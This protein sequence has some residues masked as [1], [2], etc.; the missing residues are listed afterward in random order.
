MSHE[1]VEL[2]RRGD[3]PEQP[4]AREPVEGGEQIRPARG[5]PGA[6][7]LDDCLSVSDGAL[8]VEGCSAEGLAGRFGTPLYVVSEDHLRR[9]ARRFKR[10]FGGRWP[11]SFLLLPSIKAN[12]CLALRRVLTTEG[13]GC[14]VF[15]AGELE[16]ALR[17]GT[18]PATISLN[19]PMKDEQL[20]ERAIAEGV[21]VTLDSR[22]ELQRTAKVAARL[23]TRAHI[24]FRVRPDVG[25]PPQVP[26]AAAIANAAA[27]ALGRRVRQLPMTPE[28]VWA[29]SAEVAS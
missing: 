9:N 28:R 11:G 17:T 1:D 29:A 19:G 10:A 14:D 24:R 4:M 18:S 21:K 15:G 13:T 3:D 12:S 8:Y 20:L 6:E 25:E 22:A 16:A 26:T 5:D 23:A 7:R 27:K 2:S